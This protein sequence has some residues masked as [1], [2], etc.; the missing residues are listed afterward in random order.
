MAI[1]YQ[2]QKEDTFEDRFMIFNKPKSIILKTKEGVRQKLV[3]EN[4][5]GMQ[6]PPIQAIETEELFIYL[7]DAYENQASKNF[8]VS[9]IRLLGLSLK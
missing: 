5:K 3:F 6:Y 1:G 9:E 7:E 8:A 2:K 4:I